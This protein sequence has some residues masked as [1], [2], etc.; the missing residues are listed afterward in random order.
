M[1]WR[2]LER[3]RELVPGETACADAATAFPDA[4]F[5]DHFPSFP[6]TPGVLLAE[7]GAQ[8]SGL[9]VQATVLAQR[10]F[11]IFPV[12]GTIE[13]AKF[14]AFVGP[15]ARVEVTSR[16]ESLRDEAALCKAR[17][18][19]GGR[20]SADMTLML[21]F[22]PEGLA[23]AADRRVL[24]LR[25]RDEYRR[26]ASPWQPPASDDGAEGDGER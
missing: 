12:L 9:L 20:T 7:M 10:G 15:R 11:W 17:I 4:L 18:A 25:A 23:G 5:D 21:V 8:L 13:R 3:V 1:R 14:R 16:I 24:E 26:L 22:D 6:V 2:L 19:S